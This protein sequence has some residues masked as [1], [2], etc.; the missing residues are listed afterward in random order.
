MTVLRYHRSPLQVNPDENFSLAEIL[1]HFLRILRDGI[2][3][4]AQTVT[5]Y[6]QKS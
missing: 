2:V 4:A 3:S 1:E 5:Y 6:L